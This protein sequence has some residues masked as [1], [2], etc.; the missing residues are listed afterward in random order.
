MIQVGH[1]N[2][3]GSRSRAP[4]TDKICLNHV[5]MCVSFSSAVLYTPVTKL[6]R[7]MSTLQILK[8]TP[9]LKES[10]ASSYFAHPLQHSYKTP[11][12][13]EPSSFS[14]RR[15]FRSC[16]A[17]S[18]VGK[19]GS[20]FTLRLEACHQKDQ[21]LPWEVKGRNQFFSVHVKNSTQSRT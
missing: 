9:W 10:L 16:H 11:F 21:L 8:K 1:E 5:S 2:A 14:E 18:L 13:K 19:S 20:L 7:S 6:T 4:F 3:D 15:L 12:M 17:L